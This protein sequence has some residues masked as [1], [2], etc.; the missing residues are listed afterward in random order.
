MGGPL[1][2][3]GPFH[4]GEQRQ[5]QERDTA[6]ALLGGVDRQRVGERADADAPLGQ[7]VDEVE[8]LAEVAADPV[9]RGARSPRGLWLQR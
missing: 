5:Q 7:V 8:D 1:G 9:L 4:L 6:H 3:E 2:G